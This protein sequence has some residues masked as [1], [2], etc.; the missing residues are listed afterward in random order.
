MVVTRVRGGR[1]ICPL[2]LGVLCV[3]V[4]SVLRAL[5]VPTR[6]AAAPRFE[7]GSRMKASP[8]RKAFTACWRISATSPPPECRFRRQRAAADA[9]QQVER[10]L[11]TDFKGAQIAVDAERGV[12]SCNA[13][14]S[15]A[16]SCTSTSTVMPR[17]RAMVFEFTHHFQVKCGGNQQ[18]SVGAHRT[19][20]VHLI[21]VDDEVLAQHG[22][23]A[24]GACRLQILGRTLEKPAI[25]QYRQAGSTVRSVIGGNLGGRKS[26][27]M[28]PFDGLAS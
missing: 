20:F 19:C 12:S 14:S 18:D 17:L 16:P 10:V 1:C 23:G 8:T 28:T 2:S 25:G 24:G 22:Q 4:H 6:T 11:Q 13:R 21:G 26:G 7:L 27:R 5:T 3:S 9:G 15:S